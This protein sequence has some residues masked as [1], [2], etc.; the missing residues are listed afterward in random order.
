MIRTIIDLLA[1]DDWLVC[2]EDI[3]FAKGINS[4]PLTF[5]EARLKAKRK[6]CR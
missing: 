4:L 5:K 6:K 3:D 2:D 1:A